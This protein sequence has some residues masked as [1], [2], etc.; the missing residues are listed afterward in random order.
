MITP[1]VSVNR[2]CRV[3]GMGP[4]YRRL[5]LQPGTTNIDVGSTS[6]VACDRGHENSQGLLRPGGREG[7][8][9]DR[10]LLL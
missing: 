1:S 7:T 6:Q 8:T 4:E 9:R 5:H 10:L 3:V 2:F